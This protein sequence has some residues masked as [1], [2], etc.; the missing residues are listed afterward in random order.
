MSRKIEFRVLDISK[1]EWYTRQD[2]TPTCPIVLLV[3]INAGYVHSSFS[4]RCLVANLGDLKERT[5]CVE[6]D[7]QQESPAHLVERLL[8]HNPGII[9]FSVYIWNYAFVLRVL[10]LLEIIAPHVKI[11]VG[12]PQIVPGDAAT[13]EI[14]DLADVAIVGEA[15]ECIESVLKD[16]WDAS[17]VS[18]VIHAPPVNVANIQLP[19]ALYS[20]ADIAHRVIYVETS[21]GCPFHC[22]YCTSAGQGPIRFFPQEKL[23]PHFQSLLERGARKFKFLDRSFNHNGSHGL[24][25]LDFFLDSKR[26]RRLDALQLHFEFTPYPLNGEWRKRLSAFAPGELHLEV[27]IQTWDSGVAARIR[28]PMD[29]DVVMESLRFLIHDA[30]A[31]VHADLIVGLPGE[32]RESISEGFNRLVA[33]RPSE[34]QVGILKDLP[35][36]AMR[37]HAQEFRLVFSP[38]PPYE[39]LETSTLP[40]DEMCR[41]ARFARCWDMI[42]NHRRFTRSVSLA[43][44]NS[45]SPFEDIMRLSD[46]IYAEHRRMHALSP[47]QIAKALSTLYPTLDMKTALET[48]ARGEI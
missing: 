15:E 32:T 23:W 36:T 22:D 4:L 46:A 34:I 44:E 7:G 18:S 11:V 6:T 47:R 2:V 27:G 28:R 9:G 33:L 38:E 41:L 37:R 1:G 25:V 20:A 39:I 35:G 43:L 12:G 40:F 14:F 42:Y 13:R 30:K 10:R 16:L 17:P 31:D 29:P 5:Q 8:R 24:A 21:R 45:A 48:D 26:E 19:Y 3:A